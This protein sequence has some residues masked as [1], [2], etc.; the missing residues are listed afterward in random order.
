MRRRTVLRAAG[1][2]ATAVGTAGCVPVGPAPVEVVVLWSGSELAAFRSVVDGFTR[3]TGT[4]VN[5]VSGGDDIDALIRARGQAGN[6]PHLA[7]VSQPGLITQ[8]AGQGLISPL[9][10]NLAS[11]LADTWRAAGTVDASLYGLCVKAAHKSLFWHRPST[12][13]TPPSTW[14]DLVELVR[15]GTATLSV[16]AADGWVLTD[17]FEN[18]LASL[19]PGAYEDLAKPSG[20]WSS[21]AVR[22][23]LNRL[24][25]LWSIPGAF[26]DGAGRALLTQF[27]A[28][29]IAVFGTG[30]ADLV[31]EAD[32]V[33][34]L[35]DTFGHGARVDDDPQSV[36][37]PFPRTGISRRLIVGGDV[38]VCFR[39]TEDSAALLSYLAE[40]GSFTPWI[41]LGGYLSPNTGDLPVDIYPTPLARQLATE[42]RDQAAVTHFDLSDRLTGGLTGGDG[43]GSWQILQD[44]FR[45]ASAARSDLAR[46]VAVERTV[47]DLSRAAAGGPG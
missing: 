17:W 44:F 38:A 3:R 10:P 40:P 35:A 15:G 33:A 16:G 30:R 34:P 4:R 1:L 32:F 26:P 25:D 36:I 23:T 11:N 18:V 14:D 22:G 13:D 6:L 31:F 27:D 9:P 46:A 42:L 5:V 12:V 28:S 47:E 20:S 24:A 21:D 45:R 19:D 8:Y 2:A 41:R 37:F 39:P 7:I 29:V 43:R